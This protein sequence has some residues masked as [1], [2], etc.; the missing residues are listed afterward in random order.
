MKKAGTARGRIVVALLLL[1]GALAMPADA[2][3]LSA[4]AKAPLELPLLALLLLG[5]RGRWFMA[6]RLATAALFAGVTLLKTA[7]LGASAAFGRA[8][9][10]AVDLPLV[11]AG[12]N[13]LSGTVGTAAASVAAAAA[14][15][16]WLG[17]VGL[18]FHALGG[19]S[20]LGLPHRRRLRKA[21]TA[22]AA[23]LL[24]VMA[25]G[26]VLRA[27][28]PIEAAALPFLAGHATAMVRSLE[29]RTR[30]SAAIADDP[31]SALGSPPLFEALRGK[32]VV[33][34]FVESYGRSAVEDPRYREATT[35]RL[36]GIEESLSARGFLMASG[37]LTSPTV[38][39]QS[40]LA[41]GALLSGL[42]T[43]D[44]QRYAMM[45][46]SRR[47]TLNRLFAE[48]GWRTLAVM[49]G[50]TMDWPEA[51]YF[52]YREVHAARDLGYRGLDF[53]W[54]TMPDQYTL[55]AFER[56]R[57]PRPRTPIMA[58][59]ALLSSHAP[60][61]P[62]ADILPWETVGDGSV[63]SAGRRRG[64]TPE[65]VWQDP[66]AVRA[67]YAA[68]IDYT[69][70]TIGGFIERHGRDT[71]FVILG[72]HQPAAIVTGPDVSR[73]VPVHIVTDDPALIDRIRSWDWTPG[74]H[75]AGDAPIWPM[76]AFRE[77]FVRSFGLPGS[78]TA[79]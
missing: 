31:L 24:A 69:L 74:L 44:G 39:G 66:D 64:D 52:G 28:V 14:V 3:A 48:A 36:A 47:P 57:P 18:L 54:V 40:W 32:D 79:R 68:S 62:V 42:P 12:W 29:D 8:F 77:R 41:H 26:A 27:P 13:L 43:T 33:V 35:A 7:D 16:L 61:T 22:L 4:H 73:D 37:W 15:I 71:V 63:F 65:R 59:I 58:E 10:P 11:A 67:A 38:G 34:V 23:L 55:S 56:L 53:G 76:E 6:V 49:P 60:W 50:I 46:A 21:G 45:I 75:P 51:A 25:A 20:R 72:D 9:N 2:G 17:L 1:A 70:T 5:V 19:F 30:F 78:P